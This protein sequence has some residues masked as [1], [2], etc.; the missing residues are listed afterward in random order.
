MYKKDGLWFKLFKIMPCA[1]SASKI[2][3]VP[4][5]ENTLPYVNI[6]L[7]IQKMCL[8]RTVI[9]QKT[10]PAHSLRAVGNPPNKFVLKSFLHTEWFLLK[11]DFQMAHL[12][13]VFTRNLPLFLRNA[14]TKFELNQT[15]HSWIIT[16]KSI[17]LCLPL[18]TKRKCPPYR[19]GDII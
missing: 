9:Q 1:F 17:V 2:T 15:K 10:F 18:P 19:A 12:V 6:S 8:P 16:Q 5:L 3:L 13:L 11:K 14:H 4:K 7:H